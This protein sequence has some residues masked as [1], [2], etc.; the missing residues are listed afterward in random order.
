MKPR[1]FREF[2]NSLA[3]SSLRATTPL[4]FDVLLNFRDSFAHTPELSRTTQ[5]FRMARSLGI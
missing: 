4:I 2:R 3:T 1:P 5:A